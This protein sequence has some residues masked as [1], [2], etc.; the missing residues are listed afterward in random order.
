MRAEVVGNG[1][2]GGCLELM[3]VFETPS[4]RQFLPVI[5][6]AMGVAHGPTL[7]EAVEVSRWQAG[8][9]LLPIPP[10]V[11]SPSGSEPAATLLASL[12]AQS[13]Q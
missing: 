3:E 8:T 10:Q 13:W 6:A 4:A 12:W 7:L 11:P 5:V 1:G 9:L 2:G